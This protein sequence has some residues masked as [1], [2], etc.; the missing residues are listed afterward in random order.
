MTNKIKVKPH[1]AYL[2]SLGKMLKECTTEERREYFRISDR[3]RYQQ[4]REKQL[5]FRSEYYHD[6][7]EM[8]LKRQK[9]WYY[10]DAGR[11][12]YKEVTT[13]VKQWYSLS[14]RRVDLPVNIEEFTATVGLPIEE[15]IEHIESQ[16]TEGMSWDN[17]GAARGEGGLSKVW[18][19]DHIVSVNDGGL[20]HHSNLRPLWGIKNIMRAWG[21]IEEDINIS[22]LK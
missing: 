12:Y 4:N 13:R 15:F 14:Q 5:A 8:L 6:N 19:I 10:S 18:H 20:N 17:W 22:D 3:W 21:T 11:S 7:K 16:F 1:S 9:G 2:K